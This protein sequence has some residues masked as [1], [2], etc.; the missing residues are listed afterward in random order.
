M[1]PLQEIA[2][3]MPDD[4]AMTLRELMAAFFAETPKIEDQVADLLRRYPH[5][6]DR[7]RLATH[8]MGYDLR[9]IVT[10][11]IWNFLGRTYGHPEIRYVGPNEMPTTEPN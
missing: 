10:A 2:R 8:G 7:S 11:W 4:K 5:M 9:G 6:L 1:D 3:L